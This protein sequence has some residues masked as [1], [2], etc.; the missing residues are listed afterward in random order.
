[1][2]WP[3]LTD[4]VL[5][6]VLVGAA[7]AEMW[8]YD[9][10]PG[11]AAAVTAGAA[12][13]YTGSLLLRTR[14]PV[15]ATAAMSTVLVCQALL[16]GRL[17]STLSVA[18]A[19]MVLSLSLGLLLQRRTA[20]ASAGAFLVATWLDILVLDHDDFGALSDLV[21]TT[22]MVVGAPFLAGRALRERRERAEEL[23]RVNDELSR[24]RDEVA[25]LAAAS[26]RG[27]IAREVHDVVAHSVS[28][29]VVQ[30]GAARHLLDKDPDQSRQALAAVESVGREALAELRTTLD[31]M[32]ADEADQ[33][34]LAPRPDLRQLG[35]LVA[36]MR[37]AGVSVTL[38]VE[39]P[40][41]AESLSR[42]SS[43]AAYRIV[44][45]S[46]TNVLKHTRGVHACVSLKPVS[47]GLLVEIADDGPGARD[48]THVEGPP[49]HG[50]HGMTERARIQG[51]TLTAAA[52][53]TG[54]A[55]RAW[56]PAEGAR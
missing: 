40:A 22:V 11:G 43:V 4:L 24:Q 38:S 7:Q 21:F 8:W 54:F 46:L 33:M 14:S 23:E 51:G 27:R 45:E 42:G 9:G 32:R 6:I 49:G 12:V 31:V 56:L 3:P 29:M 17:T 36:T 16:G 1:M 55:V 44:Q 2:R 48:V 53:T 39:D 25:R 50:I 20:L 15:A 10:G 26:E 19:S 41:A 34:G 52:T 35:S 47:G 18:L 13:L 28:L 30:A 37:A 5:V